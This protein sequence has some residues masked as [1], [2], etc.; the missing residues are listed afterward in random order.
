M[1][2]T[3]FDY[4]DIPSD[5]YIQHKTAVAYTPIYH[6]HDGYEIYVF[7]DGA[8]NYYVEQKCYHL[9]RG[10]I[11]II[12]PNEFHRGICIN[13][14]VYERIVMNMRS[15]FFDKIKNPIV[16]LGRCFWERE[17]GCNNLAHMNEH[18]L[19][20][21][22]MLSYEL[23]QS[24]ESGKEDQKY[25]MYS[26]LVELLSLVNRTFME[27]DSSSDMHDNYMPPLVEEAMAYIEKNLT[28]M[29]SHDDIA[30]HLYHNSTYINRLFK[31]ATGL[32]MTQYIIH[33]R[34]SLATNYLAEGKKPQEVCI[35]SGFNDY[36]NFCR[37]F[38][39]NVG[40][41]PSKYRNRTLKKNISD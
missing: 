5:L 39:K 26:A 9:K 8:V 36:T 30:S 37:T 13:P 7:L 18:D 38:T 15:S 35:L 16:D 33:K 12:R 17:H 28:K 27:D 23:K 20:R 22:I 2:I 3:N 29:I 40:C 10:D 4:D 1:P 32:T 34:L 19:D 11:V 21:L 31:E 6:Y 25:I 24:Y 41:A 14:G